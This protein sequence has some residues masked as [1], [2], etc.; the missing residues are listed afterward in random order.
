M[1][2]ATFSLLFSLDREQSP[3]PSSGSPRSKPATSVPLLDVRDPDD[4][5]LGSETPKTPPI[6]PQDRQ[7]Y[8]SGA[9]LE[10]EEGMETIPHIQEVADPRNCAISL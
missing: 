4:S 8:V 2:S 9:G 1:S 6:H 3:K 10:K 7:H 5:P